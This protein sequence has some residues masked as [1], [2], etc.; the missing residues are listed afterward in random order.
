MRSVVYTG[1]VSSENVEKL[2]GRVLPIA[3]IAVV[4]AS[5]EFL[6]ELAVRMGLD[7]LVVLILA[8]LLMA[9]MRWAL[10]FGY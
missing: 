4:I 7:G 6:S 2:A 9:A 8:L 10:L 1:L 3:V 5:G